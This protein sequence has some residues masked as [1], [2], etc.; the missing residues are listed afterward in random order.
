L[1]NDP[2][3]KNLRGLKK[4][5]VG[6]MK[7]STA[8]HILPVR[9]L[10][11]AG[12]GISEVQPVFLESQDRI[13]SGLLSGELKAAGVKEGLA[14]KF[15]GQGL[16]ILATSQALPNFALCALPTLP[17]SVRQRL[18]SA[19]MRLKPLESR[20]DANTVKSWDDEIKHGFV[21]P[22]VRYLPSVMK[23]LEIFREVQ[24]EN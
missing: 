21:Q 16:N 23:V 12:I 17:A 4:E 19:I 14:I 1:T 5:K 22:D 7:G 13:I 3:V 9:M 8:A 20:K 15:T 11:D 6:F 2:A 18:V 24:H 10:R